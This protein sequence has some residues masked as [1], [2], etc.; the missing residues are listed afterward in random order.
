V[1][2]EL[3]FDDW[4]DKSGRSVYGTNYELSL[5][6]FHSGTIF[7][8]EIDLDEESER[9]LTQALEQGFVPVFYITKEK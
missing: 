9:K 2:V 6:D 7:Q 4:R 1:K 3:V 8:G 5:S